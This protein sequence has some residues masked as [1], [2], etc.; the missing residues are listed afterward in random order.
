MQPYDIAFWINW[1]R[2]GKA[3]CK[4]NDRLCEGDK[5]VGAIS[6]QIITRSLRQQIQDKELALLRNAE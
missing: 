6:L 2:L 1:I 5:T 4:E 3:I